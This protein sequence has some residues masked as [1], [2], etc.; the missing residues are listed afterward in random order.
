MMLSTH[1]NAQFT[2][3]SSLLASLFFSKYNNGHNTKHFKWF[4]FMR[5]NYKSQKPRYFPRMHLKALSE[6]FLVIL[7]VM[8]SFSPGPSA[9]VL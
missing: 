4:C 1:Y 9:I 8:S 2:L 6:F 3:Y 5:P 7:G